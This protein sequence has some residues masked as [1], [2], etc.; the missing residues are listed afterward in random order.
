MRLPGASALSE[1][2]LADRIVDL[3]LSWK[4]Q[5]QGFDEMQSS[6]QAAVASQAANDHQLSA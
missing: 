5:R 4:A 3:P 2:Y 1:A 6:I